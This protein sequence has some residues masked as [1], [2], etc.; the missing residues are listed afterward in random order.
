MMSQNAIAYAANSLAWA[1]AGAMCTL[2]YQR[3][4]QWYRERKGLG[5][6]RVTAGTYFGTLLVGFTVAGLL[7]SLSTQIKQDKFEAC[8]IKVNLSNTSAGNQ[9]NQRIDQLALVL[10]VEAKELADALESGNRA[11][12]DQIQRALQKA[13]NDATSLQRYNNLNPSIPLATCKGER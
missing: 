3:A 13:K 12:L 2:V 6:Y 1:V 8:Q 9:R 10:A 4:V 5:T 7:L 11:A